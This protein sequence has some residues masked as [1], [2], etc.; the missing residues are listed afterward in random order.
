MKRHYLMLIT[1]LLVIAGLVSP[2]LAQT[3]QYPFT[4]NELNV[5]TGPGMNYPI[6]TELAPQTP[7]VIEAHNGNMDWVLVHTADQHVRGWV[8][9]AYVAYPG[10]YVGGNVPV[11]SEIVGVTTPAVSL[12][13]MLALHGG[14]G[15]EY[16]VTAQVPVGSALSLEAR[17]ADTGW[18]L[19]QTPDQVARGW[20]NAAYITFTTIRLDRLPVSTGNEAPV[21]QSTTTIVPALPNTARVPV[22]FNLA[23][24]E[25]IDLSAYPVVGTAT[26]TA[27]AIFLRGR[28]MG[29]DP[30]QLAKIGDCFSEHDYF[31]KHYGWQRYTLG[32]YT[33]LQPVIDQFGASMDDRSWGAST[34]FPVGAVMDPIWANP[35]A[36]NVPTE[37]PLE[38]EY[39]VHNPSVAVIMFGTQDVL[40]MTPEQFDD[41]LRRVVQQTVDANIVPILSTFP[42]NIDRWDKTL[43][44]NKI[45]I[46]VALDFDIPLINLWLGLEG[47]PN[48][49]LRDNDHLSF[50]VAEAGDLTPENLQTGYTYRN[51]VTLQTLDNVWRGA[52]Q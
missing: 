18:I 44:Y 12:A 25:Q 16:P 50:P 39:R 24:I 8:A 3:Q 9:N 29:R 36:C 35:E 48:H 46:N 23:V 20:V 1:A 51:F 5:R 45:V 38:C 47:L 19:A 13:P 14:P 41:G 4:T 30:H 22:G 10:G 32:E 33:Y 21:D 6:I 17:T 43:L 31:L 40:L 42:S 28:A 26:A 15:A 27:R 2:V 37:T 49:G 34:G 11:S 7:L 52:M